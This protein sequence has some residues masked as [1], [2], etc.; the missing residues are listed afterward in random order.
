MFH[1]IEGTSVKVGKCAKIL[2]N[3]TKKKKLR[4]KKHDSLGLNDITGIY[5]KD[6]TGI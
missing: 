1:N 5:N 2:R 6:I 4:S 3:E